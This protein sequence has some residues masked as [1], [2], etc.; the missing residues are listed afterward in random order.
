[1]ETTN[2]AKENGYWFSLKPH[3]YVDFKENGI[4]LYNTQNGHYKETS[5]KEIILI[6]KELYE[7]QNLGVTCINTTQYNNPEIQIFIDDIIEE[8]MGNIWE[9][10]KFTQKPISLIPILNLQKDV[11]RLIKD[12]NSH[13]LLSTNISQYLIE[14]NIYLNDICSENCK[15]CN[16]YHKQLHCCKSQ[17]SNEEISW[18]IFE[19]IIAQ[20]RYSA[21]SRINLLGGDIYKY[22][23]LSRLV[24]FNEKIGSIVHLYSYYKNYIQTEVSNLFQMEILVDYPL[25]IETL[26]SIF[27][28]AKKDKT[29]YHFIITNESEYND[30]ER[31]IENQDIQNFEIVP[32]YTN[33]N[34]TFFTEN[35]FM[36]KEDVFSKTL[37]IREIFRNQKLNSNYFGALFILPNG[38]VTANLNTQQIGNIKEDS[39]LSLIY[40]E[41]INNTA[42][43]VIREEEPCN[44]C[45]YQFI[46]PAPSNYENIISKNNLCTITI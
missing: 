10:E 14:L 8:K 31:L 30:S 35:V 26:S 9:I 24:E 4:L 6:I 12:E 20:I 16:N 3:I 2:K 15:F 43:R 13:S 18:D 11:D 28:T 38:A 25:E 39:I 46:C 33:Q 23:Q 40:K 45:T 22:S 7:T 27:S 17:N 32:F 41:L 21:V 34:L 42:W 1:M 19:S 29:T 44:K 36:N 5:S 37:S